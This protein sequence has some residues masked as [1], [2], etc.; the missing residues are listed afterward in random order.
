[1]PLD[2]AQMSSALRAVSDDSISFQYTDS[3]PVPQTD[4]TTLVTIHGHTFHG[5]I[6]QRLLPLASAN[7]IRL[8]NVNRREYPGSTPYTAE[9]LKTITTGSEV[10]R[11]DFL[12]KQGVLFAL[13]VDGLIQK[14][15][16]P[17]KG[18]VAIA[19]WSLGNIF[20]IAFATSIND[21]P[22]DTKVRLKSYVKTL[23]LWDPP[24][25]AFGIPEPPGS[26]LPLWAPELP[27]EVRGAVFGKWCASYFKHGNLASRDFSELNQRDAD[28]LRPATIETM[29]QEELFSVADFAPGP[30][31][32]T[33]LADS[34][35]ESV[36]AAQRVKLLFESTV[37]KEWGG[38]KI[39]HL[40]GDANCWNVIYSA[41]AIEEKDKSS[42]IHTKIIEGANHFLMWES[43]EE[44]IK[45]LRECIR[46]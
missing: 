2:C 14:L 18:G 24:S 38:V 3:G 8:V 39:W 11:A 29:T 32:E 46:S 35:F 15:D 27:V 22:D 30:K 25:Q 26:Y 6:F 43:P 36:L 34:T 28:P 1:M 40:Y 13:F 4:Y 7:A 44:A 9:E 42:S 31:C 5:A 16:L 37:Q 23:I 41:W 45:V 10:E 21:V 19:G 33:I 12:R 17:E 20:A